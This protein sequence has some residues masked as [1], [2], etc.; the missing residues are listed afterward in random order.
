MWSRSELLSNSA[1]YGVEKVSKVAFPSPELLPTSS[2]QPCC[3]A[4]HLIP[5][6]GKLVGWEDSRAESF[7]NTSSYHQMLN[8]CCL[9]IRKQ[10]RDADFFTL[11]KK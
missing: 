2:S 7:F 9:G 3:R 11:F 6:Q 8:N 5:K 4:K 10:L 1:S